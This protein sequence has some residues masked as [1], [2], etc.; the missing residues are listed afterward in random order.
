MTSKISAPELTKATNGMQYTKI[1]NP[2]GCTV[3]D[4]AQAI[5]KSIVEVYDSLNEGFQSL[6]RGFNNIAD[7][8]V[9]GSKLKDN[10]TKVAKKCANQGRY[11]I[12]RKNE[13]NELFKYSELESKITELENKL[14]DMME[15]ITNG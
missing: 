12:A 5:K 4:G 13:M 11:C 7:S 1:E 14:S 6:A 2:E 15:K 3:E 9:C 8:G 10:V